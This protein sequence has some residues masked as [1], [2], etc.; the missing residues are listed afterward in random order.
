MSVCNQFLTF[1]TITFNSKTFHKKQLNIYIKQVKIFIQLI[2]KL[3]LKNK[4]TI[5]SKIY[6][7]FF[8]LY[9]IFQVTPL[10]EFYRKIKKET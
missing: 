1:Y 3:F 7:D 10:I 6:N 9:T 8:A 2:S 5:F 4:T